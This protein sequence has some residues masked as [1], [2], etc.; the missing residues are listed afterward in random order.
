M[1]FY[2][3]KNNGYSDVRTARKSIKDYFSIGNK[4][5]KLKLLNNIF[6]QYTLNDNLVNSIESII[7]TYTEDELNFAF[8]LKHYV[9]NECNFHLSMKDAS[10]FKNMSFFEV[11]K[12]IKSVIGIYYAVANDGTKGMSYLE[13]PTRKQGKYQRQKHGKIIIFLS[14]NDWKEYIV[15][16]NELE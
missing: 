12:W 13:K 14:F 7:T 6:Y 4:E 8:S 15:S 11:L 1:E 2:T 9:F 3:L 16:E 10:F 5:L